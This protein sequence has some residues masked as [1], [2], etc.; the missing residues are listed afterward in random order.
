MK[1]PPVVI[2]LSIQYG[3]QRF[4]SISSLISPRFRGLFRRAWGF[5]YRV[6]IADIS[7]SDKNR[8][9]RRA[10]IESKGK[11]RGICKGCEQNGSRMMDFI[12]IHR[13]SIGT[14]G[15]DTPRKITRDERCFHE[16]CRE[17]STPSHFTSFS[18]SPLFLS[19][20]FATLLF[21]TSV[22]FIVSWSFA[23]PAYL[24]TIVHF[25][26]LVFYQLI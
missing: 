22:I 19:S 20:S 24:I 13:Y 7:L 3:I 25:C 8:G 23:V 9:L 12:S 10:R 16:L 6:A 5:I 15:H 17:F 26:R 4:F 14:S 1:A 2:T 11:R 18:V 21:P